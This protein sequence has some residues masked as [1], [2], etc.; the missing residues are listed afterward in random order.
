MDMKANVMQTRPEESK[1]EQPLCITSFR[2]HRYTVQTPQKHGRI[3]H[4]RNNY[5]Y[6]V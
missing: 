3:S 4:K 2:T 5:F 6:I 1:L